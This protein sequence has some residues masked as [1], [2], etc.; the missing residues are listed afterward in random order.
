MRLQ[1]CRTVLFKAPLTLLQTGTCSEGFSCTSI[2]KHTSRARALHGLWF[3]PAVQ[4]TWCSNLNSSPP[5]F[6]E[7]VLQKHKVSTYQLGNLMVL[8]PL[9]C[10]WAPTIYF[11]CNKK[12]VFF[13]F[14]DRDR[15]WASHELRAGLVWKVAK[16]LKDAAFVPVVNG[17]CIWASASLAHPRAAP[18]GWHCPRRDN[19]SFSNGNLE[20]QHDWLNHPRKIEK[21]KRMQKGRGDLNGG[22]RAI[23][24]GGD[25]E[26]ALLQPRRRLGAEFY[27][28]F[29]VTPLAGAASQTRFSPHDTGGILPHF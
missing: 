26:Q 1:Q 4:C 23:L 5:R 27:E 22:T 7:K 17:G 28:P 21:K 11:L 24:H 16:N 10:T 13:F 8:T 14:D 6:M 18:P 3:H 12:F 29:K 9:L 15:T 2:T 20:S 19:S 25:K